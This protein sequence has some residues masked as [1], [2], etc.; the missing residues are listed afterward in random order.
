M[1]DFTALRGAD[2]TGFAGGERR[3][4][5]MQHE[6]V[7]ELAHQGVDL[8][9]VARGAERGNHQRLGFAAGKQR[10][11]VSAWQHAGTDR[12]RAHG[13]GI[14][15]VDTGLAFED[16]RTHDLRFQIEHDVADIGRIRCHAA[17]RCRFSCQRGVDCCG[18]VFQLGG[19][20]LLV[21]GL[22]CVA[23]FGFGD[24][25]VVRDRFAR[26]RLGGANV[27]R[28]S[29]DVGGVGRLDSG[30]QEE[31]DGA[32]CEDFGGLSRLARMLIFR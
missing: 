19:T 29:A 12:D 9:A 31:E 6:G 13:A 14:A 4:V 1:A 11:A 21:L 15:T 8:L 23:Q 16:L 3:H 2:A 28:K 25:D 27:L 30:N 10:R 7:G 24:A 20:R 17:D 32:H 26:H 18:R 5:V 22:I